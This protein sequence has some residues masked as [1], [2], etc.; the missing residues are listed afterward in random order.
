MAT[1]RKGKRKIWLWTGLIILVVAAALGF[2]VN[3][4][5]NSTKFDPSQLGKAD[6][7]DIARSVVATGKVQPIT[8]VEVKSKA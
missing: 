4:S 5:G 2:A 3:A 1:Q 7:G 6:R 8:K